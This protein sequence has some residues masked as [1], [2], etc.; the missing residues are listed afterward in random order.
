MWGTGLTVPHESVVRIM[1]LSSSAN[2]LP[3]PAQSAGEGTSK[4]RGSQTDRAV[5]Q[6]F[7]CGLLCCTRLRIDLGAK[8]AVFGPKM[9][10]IWEGTS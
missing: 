7:P 10:Q 5:R 9:A 1:T 4:T 2:F 3:S 8:M 6:P